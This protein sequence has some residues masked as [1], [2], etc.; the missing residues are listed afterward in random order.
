MPKDMTTTIF[1]QLRSFTSHRRQVQIFTTG[2]N[3]VMTIY[4]AIMLIKILKDQLYFTKKNVYPILFC[5]D[6]YSTYQLST[7]TGAMYFS[8]SEML[9]TKPADNNQVEIGIYE[10]AHSTMDIRNGLI[11][12]AK[13]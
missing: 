10:Y 12:V 1:Y 3:T 4:E 2:Y 7:N 13:S 11:E 9:Y 6:Y 8:S 5:Q